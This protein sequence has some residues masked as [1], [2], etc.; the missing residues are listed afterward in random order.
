MT[1]STF[2]RWVPELGASVALVGGL[3]AFY[4]LFAPGVDCRNEDLST[5]AVSLAL[6]GSTLTLLDCGRYPWTVDL[7][8]V[9]AGLVCL[10]VGVLVVRYSE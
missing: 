8:L 2:G 7:R 1:T 3:V 5:W 6:D 4:A 10:V 9:G